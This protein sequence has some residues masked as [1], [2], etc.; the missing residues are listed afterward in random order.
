MF[1]CTIRPLSGGALLDSVVFGVQVPDL[2][3]GRGVDGTWVLCQPTFGSVNL[4]LALGDP[5]HLKINEWLADELFV[6]NNDFVE[7]FN[8]DSLPV[9]LG[10]CFLSDAE[11]APASSPI[12]PLSFIAPSRLC[13]LH[14]GCQSRPGRRPCELQARS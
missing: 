12:P 9:A 3:I 5:H 6:D 13:F 14:R 11:G 8:P 1:T 10:G 4:P 7:L 2:S